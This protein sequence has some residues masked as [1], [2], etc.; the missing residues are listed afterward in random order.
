MNAKLVSMITS[1]LMLQAKQIW[2]ST[3]QKTH[4]SSS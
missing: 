3:L 2:L 1:D 4:A